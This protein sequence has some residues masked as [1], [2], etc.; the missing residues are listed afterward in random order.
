MGGGIQRAQKPVPLT[1]QSKPRFPLPL[2]G[3]ELLGVCGVSPVSPC[4]R[5]GSDLPLLVVRGA[6]PAADGG[7]LGG[8]QACGWRL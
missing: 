5:P 1:P 7:P 8:G 4:T 6:W 2:P 3:C